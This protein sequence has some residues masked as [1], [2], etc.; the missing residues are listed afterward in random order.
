M[1]QHFKLEKWGSLYE[2]LGIAA[3]M[4]ALILQSLE[5]DVMKCIQQAENLDP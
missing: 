1:W 2:A 5:H 3:I 4:P